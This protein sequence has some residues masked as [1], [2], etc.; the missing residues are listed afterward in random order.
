MANPKDN[1]L[2]DR[3]AGEYR[4]GR[5]PS[6]LNTAM[7][8]LSEKH[9]AMVAASM[10]GITFQ[11]YCRGYDAAEANLLSTHPV[12]LEMV[13]ALE[14]VEQRTTQD[15]EEMHPHALI[16]STRMRAV[17]VEA[18]EAYLESIK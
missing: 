4:G 15:L 14:Y 12:I 3:L 10:A 11:S 8:F 7:K 9:A 5:F 16:R 6:F 17:I 2:R 18:L 13:E 1:A